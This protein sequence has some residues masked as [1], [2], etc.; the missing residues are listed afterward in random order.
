MTAGDVA[1]CCAIQ[2]WTGIKVG[3]VKRYVRRPPSP[4]T[5]LPTSTS[6]MPDWKWVLSWV[7]KNFPLDSC[8]LRN[9]PGEFTHRENT[10]GFWALV[11]SAASLSPR[12]GA[13]GWGEVSR[14]PPKSHPN[15]SG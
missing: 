14:G 8:L 11:P 3:V 7:Q 10:P 4:A 5:R 2:K 9:S 15:H 12:K 1:P 13:R 6:T